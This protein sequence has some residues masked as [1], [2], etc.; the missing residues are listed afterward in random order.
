MNPRKNL[1]EA[2]PL[3]ARAFVQLFIQYGDRFQFGVDSNT[4]NN[5]ELRVFISLNDTSESPVNSSIGIS[6]INMVEE[7]C[8]L[9]DE[10]VENGFELFDEDIGTNEGEVIGEY[11]YMSFRVFPKQEQQH[12]WDVPHLVVYGSLS[13]ELKECYHAAFGTQFNI[14]NIRNHYVIWGE[15]LA[16][17]DKTKFYEAVGNSTEFFEDDRRFA[18]SNISTAD[19]V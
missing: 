18:Q 7:S 8:E 3:V 4:P 15:G 16:E 10:L 14:N 1:E 12:K 2:D 19:F 5:E 17:D 11:D 13:P 6:G 9:R